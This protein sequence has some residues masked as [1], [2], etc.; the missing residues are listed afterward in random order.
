[1]LLLMYFACYRNYA[2]DSNG[3]VYFDV[4]QFDG[5][6]CHHYAKLVPEAFG[7]TKALSEGEGDLRQEVSVWG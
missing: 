5:R 2:Y 3:S 4:K 1:M 7:D 6:P